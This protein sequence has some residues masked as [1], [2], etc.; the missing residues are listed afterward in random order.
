MPHKKIGIIGCGVVG[1]ALHRWFETHTRDLIYRYDPDKRLHHDKAFEAEFIFLCVPANTNEDFSQD[2][3]ILR[4]S[5]EKVKNRKAYIFVRTTVLPGTADILADEFNL[6]VTAMPELLTER[7]AYDDME[8]LDLMCGF[9]TRAMDAASALEFEDKVKS[10]FKSEHGDKFSKNILFMRNG[11]C[12][13]A[14]YAHNLCLAAKV[15]FWNTI[16]DQ[17]EIRRLNYDN[18]VKAATEITGFIQKTHTQVPGPDGFYGFGG[19]CFPSNL[20]SFI[21]MLN[22]PKISHMLLGIYADN[23]RFRCKPQEVKRCS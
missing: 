9:P 23:N 19:K 7:T 5:L 16:K 20:T 4:Q 13:M 6:R 12:E 8:R 2:L 14:K 3:S 17:C 10:L 1:G 18:V 15:N 22:G 11:E 21:G